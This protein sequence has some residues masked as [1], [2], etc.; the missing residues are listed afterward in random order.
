M[1]YS[2]STINHKSHYK[3]QC[4]QEKVQ[5]WKMSVDVNVCQNTCF[6]YVYAFSVD[7][8]VLKSLCTYCTNFIKAHLLLN[9]IK[10]KTKT[11]ICSRITLILVNAPNNFSFVSS[12]TPISKFSVT[13]PVPSL[14]DELRQILCTL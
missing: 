8:Y 4:L 3:F 7:I 10:S 2:M 6:A 9:F 12:A 13:L 14:R 5:G 1:H 11:P